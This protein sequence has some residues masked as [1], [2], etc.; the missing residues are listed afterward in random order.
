MPV[1]GSFQQCTDSDP[2]F[3]CPAKQEKYSAELGKKKFAKKLFHK[4]TTSHGP[5]NH[6]INEK[7]ARNQG[8]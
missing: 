4:C 3:S 5:R 1:V 2:I 6:E 8:T 7:S